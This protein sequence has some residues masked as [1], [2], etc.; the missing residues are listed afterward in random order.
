[1]MNSTSVLRC[2][3]L[4]A[5]ILGRAYSVTVEIGG[6]DAFTNGRTIRLPSLPVQADATFLGLV[7]GYI[8]HE[9]AHIRHTDFAAITQAA[10]R[11]L[12]RH[13]WNIFEDWRVE[14]E[15]SRHFPGCRR[16]FHWLIRHLFLTSTDTSPIPSDAVLSWLLLRVRSWEI[17]DLD[18]RC[19]ALAEVI[20]KSWPGL[21]AKMETILTMMRGHCPD[22]MACLDYAR[23]VMALLK[24]RRGLETLL[25]SSAFQGDLGDILR[26]EVSAKAEQVGRLS[27]A[28]IG[29]K[30]LSPLSPEE[31]AAIARVT[32]GLRARFLGL[33]QAS[34]RVRSMPSR[35]GRLNSRRLHGVAVDDPVVFLS[36]E[37]KPAI[38]TALHVL[39][40]ASA[41]MRERIT[42]ACQ[43]CAALA[44]ALKQGGISVGLTAFPGSE[45][46]TVVPIFD[47]G[48][49]QPENLLV[50][51][52]GQ[53]PLGE[54][55]WWVLQRLVPLRHE[56][57]IVLI[58]TDGAPDNLVN[59]KE[60]I[61]TARLLDVQMFGLG[62]DAPAILGLLPGCSVT[63]Q[64]LDQLPSALFAL[65]G[66]A[67][68]HQGRAA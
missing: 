47:H 31:R 54:A 27:V 21:V 32:A 17:A 8:D 63:I 34:R 2:L 59:T 25:S 18:P 14:R 41:S 44:Q 50:Q 51:A 58:V 16:N 10:P 28:T 39:L 3:P 68:L 1:M 9:S 22:S 40:D 19:Q 30:P 52:R 45:P 26:Q 4:L 42:L 56:R 60:A 7:R 67:I 29:D 57:K 64:A 62:I 6:K 49:R 11:P 61:R 35:C 43:C 46:N 37:R 65:L 53:T 38:N 55:L 36:Q 15:L 20:G 24:N 13:I 12:E 5:D 33:L 66:Q 48:Q 23:Q